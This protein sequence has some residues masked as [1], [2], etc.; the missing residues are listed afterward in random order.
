MNSKGKAD[1]EAAKRKG[2]QEMIARSVGRMAK[3]PIAALVAFLLALLLFATVPVGQAQAQSYEPQQFNCGGGHNSGQYDA[4]GNLYIPCSIPKDD[5]AVKNSGTADAGSPSKI[6]VLNPDGTFLKDINF[7]QN[8]DGDAGNNIF[9]SDVAPNPSGTVL[10]FASGSFAQATEQPNAIRK[11]T[12]NAA[13]TSGTVSAFATNTVWKLA[14]DANSNVYAADFNNGRVYKYN[15]NGALA[16]SFAAPGRIGSVAVN[17]SGSRVYVVQQNGAAPSDNYVNRFD[18]NTANDTY[19]HNTAES[20]GGIYNWDNAQGGCSSSNVAVGDPIPAANWVGYFAYAWDV[21]LD[22]SG[23]IYAMN[24]TCRE[25]LKFASSG[26][27]FT[28]GMKVN[29]SDSALWASGY[30]H[31]FAVAKNGEVY[32]GEASAKMDLPDTPVAPTVSITSGPAAGS[33]DPDTT[34]T[35]GFT[36]NQAG[37]TFQCKFDAGTYANCT[38][39]HTSPTA[40]STD[41]QHTFYVKGTN[42]NGTDEETRTWTVSS[43]PSGSCFSVPAT[44]MG[45][46]GVDDISG[47]E[48]VDDTINALGGNDTIRNISGGPGNDRMCGG[49]GYDTFK[50]NYIAN[51]MLDGANRDAGA[52]DDASDMVSY[53]TATTPSGTDGVLNVDLDGT[54]PVGDVF[55]PGGGYADGGNFV[56]GL[57][58]ISDV[59][60]SNYRDSITGNNVNNALYGLSGNDTISGEGGKD[61][62][63]GNDGDDTLNTRDG[64]VETTIN[65][66]AGTGDKA[67]VDASEAANAVGCE[68]VDTGTTTIDTE[69]PTNG[70]ISITGSTGSNPGY[71]RTRQVS[72]KLSATDNVGVTSV[73]FADNDGVWDTTAAYSTSMS[74]TLPSTATQGTNYVSVRFHDA[75]NNISEIYRASIKLDTVAP[76]VI[77][78]EPAN[79]ATGIPR[80][81]ALV[82][83]FAATDLQPSTVNATS[84]YMRKNGTTTNISMKSYSYSTDRNRAIM[85]PSVALS[86]LTTYTVYIN[87]KMTDH[88]GNPIKDQNASV[89]GYQ[90][91]QWSFKTGG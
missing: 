31:G 9:V 43:T 40:L 5:P 52:T 11:L 44:K 48:G 18:L 46:E 66:G 26:K 70:T 59:E 8:L 60:G 55:P 85:W 58:G 39:P 73:S 67:V 84:Y 81:T 65:C 20:I 69:A 28:T 50:G 86:P 80:T 33:T 45:T 35:F 1:E 83:H 75:K 32:I 22:D 7:P 63:F 64:V 41:Q 77:K 53:A 56:H 6:R 16:T 36:S 89:A 88:A 87:N 2:V 38:S 90:M 34:P 19:T 71:T 27:Q 62:F 15:A 17:N 12:L 61:A 47:T 3:I 29:T 14:T 10:Y 76:S 51:A 91:K 72:L 74:Y 37:T 57:Y 82:A 68:T 30:P 24:T 23:N 25:V 79:L 13:G 4:N 54:P 78:T 42:T 21:G 49:A